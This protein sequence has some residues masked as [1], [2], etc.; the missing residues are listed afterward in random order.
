MIELFLVILKTHETDKTKL[1]DQTKYE[2]QKKQNKKKL[3][4]I[5]SMRLINKKHTVK[6]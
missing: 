2:I 4:L 1:S 5:L 6:N 3:K